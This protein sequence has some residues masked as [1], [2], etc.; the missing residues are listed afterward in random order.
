MFSLYPFS[1]AFFFLLKF[2]LLNFGVLQ[3]SLDY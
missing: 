3:R 1:G 2:I